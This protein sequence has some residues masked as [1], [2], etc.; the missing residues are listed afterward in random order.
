M[1]LR[2]EQIVEILSAD[3]IYKGKLHAE[4]GLLFSQITRWTIFF[5]NGLCFSRVV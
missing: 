4:N 1:V 5:W 3:D 2:L